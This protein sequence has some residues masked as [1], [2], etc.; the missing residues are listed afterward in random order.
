MQEQEKWEELDKCRN[1]SRRGRNLINAG[2]RIE[3]GET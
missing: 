1:K 3:L 2:T